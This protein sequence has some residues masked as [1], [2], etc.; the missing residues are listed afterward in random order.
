MLL[1]K[2]RL[3]HGDESP[4]A[5]GDALGP[6]F[7][8][9]AANGFGEE[10]TR[11]VGIGRDPAVGFGEALGDPRDHWRPK[12]FDLLADPEYR[13]VGDNGVAAKQRSHVAGLHRGGQNT[14]WKGYRLP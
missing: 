1:S 2:D 8:G 4:F 14:C 13:T 10:S 12:S 7:R 9:D 11:P 3:L 5:G 6:C